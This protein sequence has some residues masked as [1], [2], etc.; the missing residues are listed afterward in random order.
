MNLK[1]L[2]MIPYIKGKVAKQ[3]HVGIPEG[4]FEEEY[5]RNGF[6]GRY[7]HLY[8]S[9]PPVGWTKIEGPLKPRAYDLNLDLS[10]MD[11]DYIEGRK[12]IL[13]NDD[14]LIAT[15]SLNRAPSYYFRN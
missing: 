11:Q 7:A 15:S 14:V 2:E 3:A 9:E 1:R 6:F 8:R 10:Q 5:G 13:Y 12:T 4:T